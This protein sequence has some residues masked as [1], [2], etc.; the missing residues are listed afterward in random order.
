MPFTYSG[1]NVTPENTEHPSLTDIAISLSRMPRFA[2]HTR[3]W[4]SVLDHTLLGLKVLEDRN[5]HREPKLVWLLHDAHESITGDIPTPVKTPEL[6]YKQELLD[7]LIY[8]AFAPKID[9]ERWSVKELDRECMIAEAHIIGPQVPVGRLNEAFGY[10][11][12]AQDA[13]RILE[14]ELGVPLPYRILGIPPTVDEQET[15]PA[16]V[17][18]VTAMLEVM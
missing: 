12:W 6:R 16:V 8:G 3:R 7:G 14:K 2:G 5:E 4:W 10:K 15:H 9:L 17:A 18:Y 1:R 11:I 13:V